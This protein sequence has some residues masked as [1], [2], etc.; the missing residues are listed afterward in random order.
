MVGT[1]N[2]ATSHIKT[3]RLEAA[4]KLSLH[5]KVWKFTPDDG[6][7]FG[8]IT[9]IDK[10]NFG[11]SFVEWKNK[12]QLPE[13]PDLLHD[14]SQ[15]DNVEE[16]AIHA[17]LLEKEEWF[18]LY[19]LTKLSNLEMSGVETT[20][21]R[22]KEKKLVVSAQGLWKSLNLSEIVEEKAESKIL[23]L[24]LD[25]IQIDPQLQSRVSLNLA[26]VDV[27][28]QQL[29]EGKELDPVEVMRLSDG[30]L[31]LYHGFHRYQAHVKQEA[32]VIGAIVKEGTR[33][34]AILLSVGANADN[35]PQL[36]RTNADKRHAVMMLLEDKEWRQWS[37]R[38]I[39]QVC[40]VSDK[41]VEKIRKN[42]TAEF[43]SENDYSS[44]TRTY[45]NKQGQVAKMTIKKRDRLEPEED[46]F[47]TATRSEIDSK[48]SFGSISE[49][50][51]EIDLN[52]YLIAISSNIDRFNQAQIKFLVE[53]IKQNP[54][55]RKILL[56]SCET[57]PKQ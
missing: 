35:K 49:Q 30:Q 15:F 57:P 12:G 26:H 11:N 4:A 16:V 14:A 29:E 10:V 53:T 3:T 34:D 1:K 5:Q 21:A 27:L 23:T 24:C 37:S 40:R 32:E 28:V 36:A 20:L 8:T 31:L 55:G 25:E 6:Y 51:V 42:L 18:D 19:E 48:S 39:S 17:I 22:L 38:Q 44:K 9:Q 54:E 33:R 43:R 45:I 7:L 41:T 13:C 56:T 2:K 50:A 52:D 47:D 46:R